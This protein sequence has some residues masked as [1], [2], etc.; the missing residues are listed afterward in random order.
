MLLERA[1]PGAEA[2]SAAAGILGAQ[3]ESHSPGPLRSDAADGARR[4]S[5]V[6]RRAAP[7][8]YAT[9][10]SAIGIPPYYVW[11]YT[12]KEAQ[13]FAGNGCAGRR[14]PVSAP[15]FWMPERARCRSS[16]SFRT[17]VISVA[18]FPDDAQV[19]PPALL[20]ALVAAI[21]ARGRS[22]FD[23]ERHRV[24]PPHRIPEK[25]TG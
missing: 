1:I 7:E 16:P 23:R 13:N 8:L 11:R 22:T 20:R 9:S 6:E 15:S 14:L 21:R 18:H 5:R 24:A 2:S 4:I 12:E 17:E 10:T 3:I 25:C 19:D